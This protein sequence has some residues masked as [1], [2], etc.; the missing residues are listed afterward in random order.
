MAE[1]RRH[2][3][4]RKKNPMS[5]IRTISEQDSDRLA[6]L[7][8]E[9]FSSPPWNEPWTHAAARERISLMLSAPSCRGVVA[10][11]G[12]A[13]VGMTLG[14]LEGWIEGKLFLVQELCVSPSHQRNGLGAALLRAVVDHAQALENVVAVYLLTD[15]DSPA[16]AFHRQQGLARGDK[17]VMSASVGRLM[18][19]GSA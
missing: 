19:S 13:V 8:V 2:P 3:E 15:P 11:E 6:A 4:I 9:C 18:K 1:S 16:E 14:Q 7:F 5:S 17:I 10:L 12:E